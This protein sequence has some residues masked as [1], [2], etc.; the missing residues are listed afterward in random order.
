MSLFKSKTVTLYRAE[1]LGSPV[2]KKT[3]WNIQKHRDA[4]MRINTKT[5]ATGTFFSKSPKVFFSGAIQIKKAKVPK[6]V[7]QHKKWYTRSYI[8]TEPVL[9]SSIPYK[10]VKKAKIDL[11]KTLYYNLSRDTTPTS[12]DIRKEI[13]SEL[14]KKV[15]RNV[16]YE[17]S[18]KNFKGVLKHPVIKK[19]IKKVAVRTALA[20]SGVG[21]AAAVALT[22]QDIYSG[23]KWLYKKYKK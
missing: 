16:P 6:S 5:K 21:T 11:P 20:A 22:A 10:Y 23:S 7:L 8:G 19:A 4:P 13:Q 1:P 15:V 14:H 17:S 9:H 3:K 2:I 18:V 12:V